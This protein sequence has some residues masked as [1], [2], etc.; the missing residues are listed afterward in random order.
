MPAIHAPDS[1]RHR[2]LII[3]SGA[4]GDTLLLLPA[5]KALLGKT[6]VAFAGREPAIDF[7]GDFVSLCIN[8]E[9]GGWHRLFMDVPLGG[10][11]ATHP[12][13]E[14][15][16]VVLFSAGDREQLKKNLK[17][18]W[19]P[20]R[21]FL[22]PPF[23]QKGQRIHVARY[24]ARCLHSAELPLNADR[25]F[26]AA[27]TEPILQL[28]ENHEKPFRLVI[29]PGSGD[30][31]KN[32]PPGF[33]IEMLRRLRENPRFAHLTPTLLLGPA[34]RGVREPFENVKGLQIIISPSKERLVNTLG[35]SAVYLG[36]DSGITHLSGLL[37]I[38][39]VALFRSTDPSQW[40]PLGP[41]VRVV[42]RRES[43]LICIQEAILAAS[44]F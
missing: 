34:E 20:A 4:I 16:L 32:H 24:L 23:P 8:L 25:A 15:D 31:E 39:T 13:P 44:G 19:A 21:T 18:F 12:F 17:A 36:H 40:R 2:V 10:K 42:H 6:R 26:K 11:T 38:P 28:P 5:L 29:H 7:V 14:A 3:R 22:F 41:F 43:D 35:A 27:I 1:E 37:G 9:T 30:S 33:W